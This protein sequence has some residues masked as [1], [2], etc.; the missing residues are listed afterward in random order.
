MHDSG[1]EAVTA[2]L[3]DIGH[4]IDDEGI[5]KDDDSWQVVLVSDV[6]A[7]A[8][9]E[10]S[11]RG[12]HLPQ[13][14]IDKG[15]IITF[16]DVKKYDCRIIA[17][18]AYNPDVEEQNCVYSE[19]VFKGKSYCLQISRP[20]HPSNIGEQLD[21]RADIH[22]DEG[23]DENLDFYDAIFDTDLDWSDVLKDVFEQSK[24]IELLDSLSSGEKQ[25]A[26]SRSLHMRP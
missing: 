1:I 10:W 11:E 9:I 25:V 3:S 2:H 19:A 18:Q 23:H 5:L 20:R 6:Q 15:E 21:F 4:K 16:R 7:D 12:N 8:L 22:T 14:E 13:P 17:G 24:A 26:K